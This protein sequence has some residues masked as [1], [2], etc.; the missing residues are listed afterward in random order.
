MGMCRNVARVVWVVAAIAVAGCAGRQALVQPNESM[1]ISRVVLFQNGLAYVERRGATERRSIELTARRDQVDDVLKSLTV[2]DRAV[3]G[4]ADGRRGGTKVASVRV[5]PSAEGA[6]TVTL[7]VGLAK[8]GSH[9]LSISYVAEMSGWRPTYRLVADAGGRIRLQGLAVI[10]NRSGEPWTDIALALSTDVPLS[11]RYAL[12]TPQPA[13]RPQ[14]SSDGRLLQKVVPAELGAADLS[15]PGLMAAVDNPGIQAAYAEMNNELPQIS[16][17]AGVLLDNV[18]P[19]LDGTR[20]AK[21]APGEPAAADPT[22]T[23]DPIQALDESEGLEGTLLESQGG[24]SLGDGE[25]GLV[26]FVDQAAEGS[27][28]LLYKPATN[29]GP[30]SRHP[31]QAVLFR[32]PLDAPL[33]TGPVA[34]FTGDQFLGD[35]VTGTIP[36]RS[37]AFVAYALSPGV[38]IEQATDRGEDD[39]RA[40]AVRGGRLRVELQATIETRFTVASSRPFDQRLY[41]FVPKVQGY[42]PRRPPEGTVATPDGYYVPAPRGAQQR[43][44]LS[45]ELAQT[46]TSEVDI[47]ADPGHAYV[48]ALIAMLGADG[49]TDVSRLT[50]IV[51]RVDELRVE[52]Q[53]WRDDLESQREALTER[54]QALESL[55]DVPANGEIRRRLATSVAQGVAAVDEL[56]RH[57]VEANAE[58]IALRQDWYELLR[59]LTVQRGG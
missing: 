11:F 8:A 10:D 36:A 33:L 52:E 16:S 27:L 17:R 18:S 20:P 34:V 13:R 55:R 49:R 58:L 54:R 37:H 30:S 56:T 9:D 46:R 43:L 23:A 39:I 40:V 25:S 47:S 12:Q 45:F 31:Y 14:L 29:G 42:E 7:S 28:V 41:L 5:L 50:A 48:P 57:M 2:V 32:N 3:D 38:Q 1:R 51:D 22:R 59:D 21:A 4:A 44:A 26:P 15:S 19:R 35:G 6:S 53:R 24:F